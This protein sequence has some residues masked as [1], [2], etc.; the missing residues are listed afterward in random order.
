MNGYLRRGGDI[1]REWNELQVQFVG[2]VFVGGSVWVL[3]ELLRS[4]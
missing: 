1:L 2:L 4:I 3:F